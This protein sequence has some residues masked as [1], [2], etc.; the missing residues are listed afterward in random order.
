MLCVLLYIAHTGWSMHVYC[1]QRFVL[2]RAT[3]L[4]G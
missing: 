3:Y 4:V 1:D 2:F